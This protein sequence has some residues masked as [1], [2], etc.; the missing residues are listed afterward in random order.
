MALRT[1]HKTSSPVAAELQQVANLLGG[2]RLLRHKLRNPLDAHEML[3]QGLPGQALR[4]ETSLVWR[5]GA[6]PVVERFVE[7]VR[8]GSG[9]VSTGR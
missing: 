4:C 7:H 6:A 2:T 1:E 9:R 8:R 5:A 3:L